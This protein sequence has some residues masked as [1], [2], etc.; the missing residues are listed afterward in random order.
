MSGDSPTGEKTEQPTNKKLRDARKKGQ[1]AQSKETSTAVIFIVL[2]GISFSLIPNI[3]DQLYGALT[4]VI[5]A[6]G[7]LS[8]GSVGNAVS[9]VIIVVFKVLI[10][11]LLL[12]FI[13]VVAAKFMEVG[14]IF[15]SEPMKLDFSKLAFK[16]FK[17]IFSKK[18]LFN[19]FVSLL[20]TAVIST[21]IGFVIYQH[22]PDIVRAAEYCDLNCSFTL[23]ARITGISLF[24]IAI[25]SVIVACVD[26]GMQQA[27][28]KKSLMMSLYDIKKEYKETQGSPEI[29]GKRQKIHR[30]LLSEPVKQ[31]VQ[32]SAV[33]VTNPTHVAIGLSYTEGQRTLPTVCLMEV[34]NNALM[35]R[36]FAYLNDIPIVEDPPLARALLAKAKLDQYIPEEFID[37]V[38]VVLKWVREVNKQKSG[39]ESGE[40]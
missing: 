11:P 31:Q 6:S 5:E 39:S 17:N 28:H 23:W 19:W 25:L 38:V 32:K 3:F 12:T 36:R 2:T 24:Y 30:E 1:V 34:E 13:F 4:V 16:G 21:V 35:A 33:L 15:S 14:V 18:N 29:K 9:S 7:D 10:L 8:E 37:P 27:F 20:K 26:I 40:H 22:L